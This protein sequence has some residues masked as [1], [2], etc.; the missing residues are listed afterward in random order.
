MLLPIRHYRCYPLPGAPHD[1]ASFGYAHRD[2]EVDPAHTAFVTV[3]LWN[4]G[5]EA[6][7]LLPDLGRDAELAF[8]GLGRRAAAEAK[9][10]TEA[11]LAPALCAARQAGLL[12][13]HSTHLGIARKYPQCLVEVNEPTPAVPPSDW[14]PPAV[15]QATLDAYVRYTWGAVAPAIW[16]R[17]REAADFPAPVRPVKGDFCIC[18][19]AAMD[20][21]LREHRITTVVHVG[22][23]LAHCLLDKPGGIRQ[24]SAI[25]RRPGYCDVLLRDCTLAQESH[26]SIDGLRTTEAFLF[27]LEAT[28]VP[29]AT[30]ADFVR[31]CANP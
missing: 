14:P 6:E 24:T 23:L 13:I 27:W 7:P 11:N 25:W 21:L 17:M 2:L 20:H 12:V 22:F 10:R 4:M 5:W 16:E 26:A 28:G 8:I 1:E 19:Q 18:T 30:A 3:D 15:G 31:A 29:T 9:R